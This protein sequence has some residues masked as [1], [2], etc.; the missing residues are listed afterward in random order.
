MSPNE[1]RA[2]APA[3][4]L[5]HAIDGAEPPPPWP[6]PTV[7]DLSVAFPELAVHAQIGQGGMA[8]VYRATQIR[9]GRPVA[10]KV[11]RPD[12]AK[13][14]Q[15]VQRFVR[16]A[17]AL[18]VLSNPHVLT[19]HD[20]GE[21]AGWCYLVTEYI[22]GANLREL[23]QLG[24]LSPEEVLRIVPQICAGLHFAHQHG[25]VHRD[26]KPENVLV[27]RHGGVKLADFGLAKLAGVPGPALTHS[28]VV[29][30]TPHYM[31][32]EQWRGSA[33]VDHRADIYSLGVVLYELL[34]GRLPVG[35]YAPASAQP[36]VPAGIDQVVQRSLQ[37][38]PELRYQSARDV[39]QDLER[40]RHDATPPVPHPAASADDGPSASATKLLVGGALVPLLGLPLLTVFSNRE[41]SL[42]AA[43]SRDA[44][45]DLANQRLAEQIIRSVAS[46][47]PWTGA[48]PEESARLPH[49]E[50][51]HG[52][53]TILCIVTG[54]VIAAT[55]MVLGGAAWLRTRHAG[56]SRAQQLLAG[57]LFASP[58]VGGACIGLSILAGRAQ[59]EWL[60]VVVGVVVVV[61]IGAS[62]RWLWHLTARRVPGVPGPLH[63][64]VRRALWLASLVTLS[65]AA[66]AVFGPRH[67]PT[68]P[69]IQIPVYARQLIGLT[70]TQV[71]D[72]LGP[73]LGITTARSATT[74]MVWGYRGLD[75]RERTDAL[76]FD[77][78]IV[79]ASEHLDV[80]LVP[81]PLP[82]NGAH[83]GLTVTELIH[84]LG[85]AK[86][87]TASEGG[88]GMEFHDGTTAMISSDGIV[89]HVGR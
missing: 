33:D 30:G 78:G 20:F 87:T 32:P 59:R 84:I 4:I 18:A 22:D 46:G 36:G 3:A 67:E 6:A 70:R 17:K 76:Q 2:P 64:G 81:T 40:Q 37:Q 11:M 54:I 13:E 10:L 16:E 69:P 66:V 47:Q 26:I 72:K 8:A 63:P 42:W 43:A 45:A 61:G 7:A 12:L 25:V 15:F 58:P 29:M 79:T 49:Y 34:T 73:P 52:L 48:L 71:L 44:F 1:P 38:E 41:M 9:L 35:A 56:A 65:V 53:P 27:D 77:G 28:S 83:A 19:I 39:Q 50:L 89:L 14:P 57:L 23:M 68:A 74:W 31:A 80:R 75:G 60:L 21:R 55:T 82:P 88:T 85:P 86:T 51:L 24:R 5:G 62:V